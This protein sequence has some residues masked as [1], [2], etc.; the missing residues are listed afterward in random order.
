MKE[1]RAGYD[2]HVVRTEDWIDSESNPITRLDRDRLIATDSTL[3]RSTTDYVETT[4]KDDTIARYFAIAWNGVATFWWVGS[5]VTCKK[6]S[7]AQVLKL[8]EMAET[9]GARDVGDDGERYERGK[10][11]VGRLK[12]MVQRAR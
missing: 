1:R 10:T 7:N 9:L 2:L 5:E 12:V 8:I 4:G 11:F 6:A 3:A